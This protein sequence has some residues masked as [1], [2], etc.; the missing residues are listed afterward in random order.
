MQQ[1]T[2]LRSPLVHIVAF[3]LVIVLQMFLHFLPLVQRHP[4]RAGN[5][6]YLRRNVSRREK[7][8]TFWMRSAIRLSRYLTSRSSTKF[9]FD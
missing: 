9:F 6:Q 4:L 2:N 8:R 7:G 3:F 5:R 1:G